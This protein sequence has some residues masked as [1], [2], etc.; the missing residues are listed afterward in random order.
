MLKYEHKMPTG[1]NVKAENYEK[2]IF[3]ENV[4]EHGRHRFDVGMPNFLPYA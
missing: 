2:I 4:S 1:S 3:N